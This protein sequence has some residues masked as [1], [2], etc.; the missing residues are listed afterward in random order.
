MASFSRS[1]ATFRPEPIELNVPQSNAGAAAGNVNLGNTFGSLRK[2]GPR[3]DDLA[4]TA[5][6]NR[7]QERATVTAVEGQVAAQGVQAYGAT[8]SAQIVAEAQKEAAEAQARGSMMG[9]AFGAIGSIGGALIGL[10]DES[11]KHTVEKIEDALATLRNLK[12]VT[13]YYKEEYSMSPE[14]MHYGFIAQDYAKVMPDATYYDEELSKMC[15]DTSELI[16]LLVRSVQQL[17]TRVARMEAAHALAGV[18]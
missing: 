5:I 9:S 1:Q 16:S 11:T 8:K 12:P 18:K 6:A 2:N 14:R 17:E 3:F 10:S 4:A 13:F 15:I 7:A